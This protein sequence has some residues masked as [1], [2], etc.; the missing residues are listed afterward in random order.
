MS[1]DW[2]IRSQASKSL[3]RHEEG[4]TTKWF[5][6]KIIIFSTLILFKKERCGEL[7]SLRLRYSLIPRLNPDKYHE[8]EGNR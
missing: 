8:S 5:W 1:R 3:K 4:S 6:V 2:A 7:R